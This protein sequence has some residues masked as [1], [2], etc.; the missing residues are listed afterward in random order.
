MPKVTYTLNVAGE[1]RFLSIFM[2]GVSPNPIHSSHPNFEQILE[3]AQAQDATVDFASLLDVGAAVAKRF[4]KLTK[5][6]T[7]SHGVIYLDGDA[8]HNTLTQQVVRFMDEGVK[9]WQPL[10]QFF[11]KVQG[12][13]NDHSREQLYDW[14]NV[15]DGITISPIGNIVG[16]KGVRKL[17]DGS[18]VSGFSGKAIVDGLEVTGNIPNEVGTT[19]EMPRSEVVHDP[20]SACHRGLHIGTF[21]YAQGYAQG[22]MLEVHVD[23]RDV[24]SVPTD[25]AGAKVRVC[26][27]IIAGTIDTPY[28]SAVLEIDGYEPGIRAL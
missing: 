1:D 17:E 16:Y 9:D 7:V 10:V 27:Y 13:P 24:V 4:E 12:N 19:V 3:A 23:P 11:E 28:T 5:R 25:A 26:R 14:L 2:P 15:N 6:L 20:R 18:L 8:I 21:N 22:A